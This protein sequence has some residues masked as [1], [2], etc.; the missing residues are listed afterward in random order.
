MSQTAEIVTGLSA[1]GCAIGIGF[2]M[3][4]GDIA[5]QRYG[6]GQLAPLTSANLVGT[7]VGRSSTY[8]F[9]TKRSLEPFDVTSI[10]LTSAGVPASTRP[11]TEH[12]IIK[13]S[14]NASTA[15]EGVE[16]YPP[17]GIQ[18]ADICPVDVNAQPMAAAMIAYQ[19]NA[20]CFASSRVMI[21][22][23]GLSFVN[24]LSEEGTLDLL[25]PALSEE[26]RIVAV[27]PDSLKS[28]TTTHAKSVSLYDRVIVQWEGDATVQVHARE[29]GAQ[30]GDDGH[31]WSGAARD[32]SAVAEGRGGFLTALGDASLNDPRRAEVYTF[33]S[34]IDESG[35]DVN[36]TVEAEVTEDNCG[37]RIQTSAMQFSAG[38]RVFAQEMSLS[39]PDCG[40]VGRFLVLNNLLQNLTVASK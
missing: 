23:N 3:Q 27:F 19:L 7:P 6:T 33:P 9:I 18:K 22:H 5:E 24:V 10:T 31:V 30:Y 26:V 11:E 13:A 4:G 17:S 34:A 37:K 21:T 36:L 14:V 29:F 8:D 12:P 32:F 1:I 16:N 40:S 28:I 15:S 38:K 39:M 20:P 25:I 35:T 2:V